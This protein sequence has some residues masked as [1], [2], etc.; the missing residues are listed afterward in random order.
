MSNLDVLL[1]RGFRTGIDAA[2]ES[3]SKSTSGRMVDYLKMEADQIVF[4]SV[5]YRLQR[6]R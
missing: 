4:L 3:A 1:S 6:D 2:K 5:P